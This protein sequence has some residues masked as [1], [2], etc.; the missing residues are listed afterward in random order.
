MIDIPDFVYPKDAQ[1]NALCPKCQKLVAACD[2]PSLEPPKQKTAKIKPKIS[3]DKNGRK[4]KVVT[5]IGGLPANDSY[6]KDISKQL[7]M[8][9]GSGGT[10]YISEGAGMIEIQ[11][12]HKEMVTKLFDGKYF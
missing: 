1:G 5:L 7:K 3:L 8:K 10:F 12:N 9:T 11:G 4:G 6:L 2:C